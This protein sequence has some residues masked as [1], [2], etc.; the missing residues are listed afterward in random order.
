M[1]LKAKIIIGIIIFV[2]IGG[3]VFWVWN[4][5][6]G[7][8]KIG[9]EAI[10]GCQNPNQI[11][12]FLG[13]PGTNLTTYNLFGHDVLVNQRIVP[14][15]D[16]LQKDMKAAKTGY[17]FDEIET[18]NYREKI[19][20]NGISLHSW[21]IAMDVNPGRNPYQLGNYGAPQTDIPPKVVG[22]FKKN[23]FAWGG[24]WVGEEDPMHFE[25]YGAEVH[26]SF[27]D[28]DTGQKIT[29]VASYIDGNPSDNSNGD[30]DWTLGT[31]NPHKISVKA[32]G[33]QDA[34]F[35]LQLFCFENRDMDIAIKPL[36][37]NA[38]GSISGRVTLTG[39]RP[40][41]IPA[42]IY[43]DGKVVGATNVRG[44]YYITGVRAGKHKIEAQ[45]LFFPG[46]TIKTP[47]M[48]R[49][50]NLENLNFTIGG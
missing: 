18:Y 2:L 22:V 11:S 17:S 24:D 30:F 8:F 23:G 33:Y 38:P 21:G 47:N 3:G 26:G 7:H 20:G 46:T 43:L 31:I 14:S 42:T 12:S 36:P 10:I 25:W 41:V 1:S 27:V 35:D 34:E 29:N 37:T 15:L 9:A 45:I 40:P 28:A 16:S 6:T 50:E 5:W 13:A 4:K 32:P 49:G 19:G 39:N 44:D 48:A